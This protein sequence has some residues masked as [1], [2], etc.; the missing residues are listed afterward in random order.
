M[1]ASSRRTRLSGER[2]GSL[3]LV[4]LL[5]T[6]VWSL[7]SSA[8]KFEVKRIE[9]AA[10]SSTIAEP[11]ESPTPC[12]SDKPHQLMGTYYS[13]NNG[14]TAKLLLNNKGPS[15]LVAQ[16]T[17]FAMTGE[18][19]DTPAVTVDGQSFQ[20]IDLR[21]WI[22]T[23]GPQFQEGSIQV[24]HVGQD[25]VLGAQVYLTNESESLSFDEKLVELGSF[26]SS[27]LEGLWWLPKQNGK[28]RVALSNTSA[29]SLAVTVAADGRTPQ[30]S[31]QV[32]VQLS[33]KET[34]ILD[35]R[36][37]ILDQEHGA[38]SRSGGISISHSGAPGDLL[39]RG[40]AQDRVLGYSLPI[41]FSDP[42]AAKSAD[43]QGVGLRLGSAGGELLKPV[44]VVRNAGADATTVSGRMPYTRDDGTR[45]AIVL[46]AM[47]LAA[48]DS[49]TVDIA[50][51][52]REQDCPWFDGIGGL[53]FH[54]STA[55]GSVLIT[56][57]SVSDSSNQV[58]RVPMWDVAAQRSP[59]GG[60]PWYID[61]NSSTKV[62]IKNALAEPQNYFLQVNYPG[63]TY[64]IGMKSLAG[65]E[66]V[67]YDLRKLRDEQVPDS[68]GRVIPLD[69]SSGQVHW[70]ANGSGMMIGRSEQTDLVA[71]ISS[72]YACMNCCED[73]PYEERV[74]PSTATI[75]VD[76]SSFF[77]AE[78]QFRDCY[79]NLTDFT[80]VTYANW[81]SSNQDVATVEEIN[82]NATG[83]GAGTA[84]ITASWD[85]CTYFY[86]PIFG[87]CRCHQNHYSKSATV[88]IKP[89]L[90]G[91][92]TVW[93]FNDYNSP[94]STHYPL[95]STLNAS[96]S[97][98]GSYTFRI[99]SGSDK[100]G[101]GPD[102]ASSYVTS[103]N[104]VDVTSRKCSANA[105]D[106]VVTVERN[107]QTSAP[108]SLTVRCPSHI[109]Q[110]SIDYEA[111]N[112]FGFVTIITYSVWDNLNTKLPYD[113]PVNEYFT[114][115]IIKDYSGTN[116]ERSTPNGHM[117]GNV[118]FTD[119]IGID[120]DLSGYT[121]DPWI[122]T[123]EAPSSNLSQTRIT[124]F[125]QQFWIGTLN[126]G[127]GVHVQN[128]TLVFYLDHGAH[129]DRV[130]PVS[131]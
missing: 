54:Y 113:L 7:Q 56:A 31:G 39:A 44:V 57:L 58:F 67:T 53:E 18:R 35:V 16:P 66:T 89:T 105:N 72:N 73:S 119:S 21:N 106:V 109:Q 4:G 82:G 108:L 103:S 131:P 117:T 77:I 49:R 118:T 81:S 14:L 97:G 10:L 59:T 125:G 78:E 1:V 120:E 64:A 83:V 100:A 29:A 102:L 50:Q 88:T 128:D 9:S 90:S 76:Q 25:L 95:I 71:G 37:D 41:Q 121:F 87:E 8:S 93:W 112:V 19:F 116:W 12:C 114:T 15:P 130:S 43:V 28:I 36:T 23:A 84:T 74:T 34:R 96:E 40:F 99:T 5:L 123:P 20:M 62:Y 107:G 45:D 22:Q 75:A 27:R 63:G 17:L 33:A 6:L 79:G 68:H 91:P 101:L 38:I 2:V 124:H 52:M 92:T 85:D 115:E 32:T 51:V 30:R 129:E 122:P 98:S 104:Q 46:P 70:S 3:L 86:N 126:P 94:D 55:P 60:Y 42:A 110:D 111:A 48:G 24:F 61:G 80:F 127:T 13:I 47:Y 26:K 69:V 65:G 11:I